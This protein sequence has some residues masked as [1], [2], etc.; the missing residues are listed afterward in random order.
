MLSSRRTLFFSVV[1]LCPRMYWHRIAAAPAAAAAAF[2]GGQVLPASWRQRFPDARLKI[3]L[4]FHV[5]R[6]LW[7]LLV[8]FHGTLWRFATQIIEVF[9]LFAQWWTVIHNPRCVKIHTRHFGIFNDGTCTGGWFWNHSRNFSLVTTVNHFVN[10]CTN[11]NFLP[12]FLFHR[13]SLEVP[14]PLLDAV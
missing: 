7:T 1:G 3:H 8:T 14:V 12:L 9:F 13:S 11:L 10:D 5:V 4:R 2:R 6:I